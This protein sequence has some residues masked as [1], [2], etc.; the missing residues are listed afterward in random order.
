MAKHLIQS[1]CNKNKNT[2]YIKYDTNIKTEDL[3]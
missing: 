3:I 1:Y 2:E